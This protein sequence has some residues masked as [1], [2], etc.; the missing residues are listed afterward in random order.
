MARA[1]PGYQPTNPMVNQRS[2][3][4]NTPVPILTNGFQ[5]FVIAVTPTASFG[6]VSPTEVQLRF[7][8]ANTNPADVISGANRRALSASSSPVP[9]IELH[10]GDADFARF[11]GLRWRNSLA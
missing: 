1:V 3:R 2:G 9:D 7:I 10:S 11:P 5:T 4:P 8:C 6:P